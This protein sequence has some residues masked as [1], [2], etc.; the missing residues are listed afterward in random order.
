MVHCSDGW[1]RTSQLV[2]LAQLMIDPS[3]RTLL[4]FIHLIQKEFLQPGHLFH[5]RCSYGTSEKGNVNQSPI[6][7]QFLGPLRLMID[8]LTPLLTI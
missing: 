5:D 6:F 1:D 2:A 4:G 3:Y 7:L 8:R